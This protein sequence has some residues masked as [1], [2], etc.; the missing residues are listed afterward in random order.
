[1][2]DARNPSAPATPR[3]ALGDADDLM[4]RHRA[5]AAPRPV[6]PRQRTL[7]SIPTLTDVVAGPV[8]DIGRA[9]T[10]PTPRKPAAPPDQLR[11]LEHHVFSRI[12]EKLDAEI[13]SLIEQRLMPGAADAVAQIL[14]EAT[15]LLRESVR[16]LV[17]EAVEDALARSQRGELGPVASDEAADPDRER[18]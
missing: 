1:M 10:T 17:R 8:R 12:K 2:A 6:D 13:E 9:A 14:G 15:D 3:Q 7:P 5:A 16:D 4:S 11:R 18:P